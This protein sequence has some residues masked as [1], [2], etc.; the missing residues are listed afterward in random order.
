M[1]K[2]KRLV[3]LMTDQATDPPALSAETEPKST[4]I[5]PFGAKPAPIALIAS[6]AATTAAFDAVSDEL[7]HARREGRLVQVLTLDA[8]AEDHLVRD[9]VGLDETELHSLIES[10]RQRG[11]QMPIEVVDLGGGTFGLISGW[12][13]LVALRRLFD[14][15][16]DAKYNSVLALLRE[17]SD[18]SAAYVAMIEENEIRAGLSYYE[19]ARIVA[20]AVEQGVFVDRKQAL[21]TLF[22]TASRARRSKIGSFLSVVQALDGALRFPR[23]IGERLGLAL[24]QALEADPELGT[25]LVTTLTTENPVRPEDE[26]ALLSQGLRPK[27]VQP[28]AMSPGLPDI[29]L[30]RTGSGAATRLVLTGPG[31]TAAFEARL[32]DW[33]RSEG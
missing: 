17:P 26:L 24:S 13:R 19:R 28:P 11:Q 3:P 4:L 5:A 32:K 20:K 25:R 22:S 15:T 7:R 9:R 6:D 27:K 8:I 10:L 29:R 23:L 16:G 18:A 21:Q 12:R 30:E 33:L 14:E 31:V 1:A 2:R